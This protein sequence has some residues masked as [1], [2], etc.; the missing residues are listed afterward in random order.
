MIDCIIEGHIQDITEWAIRDLQSLEN[1]L[2][3]TLSLD[4]LSVDEL[5]ARF[6]AYLLGEEEE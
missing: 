2:R 4:N 6:G 1:W 5:H 3:N